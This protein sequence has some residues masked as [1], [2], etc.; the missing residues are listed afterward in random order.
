MTADRVT[1]TLNNI[2]VLEILFVGYIFEKPEMETF[3]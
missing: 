3:Y 1:L 2:I